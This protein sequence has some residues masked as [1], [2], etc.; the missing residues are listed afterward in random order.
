MTQV[1]LLVKATFLIM[2]YNFILFQTLNYTLKR[3]GDTE[4]VVSWKSK[5]L[6]TEKV[7]TPTTTYN[8]LSPSVKWYKNS[9]FCLI[10][11]RNC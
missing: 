10:F 11:K 9:N 6:S 8:S 4:K 7:T 5:D 3:L 2:G 1:F